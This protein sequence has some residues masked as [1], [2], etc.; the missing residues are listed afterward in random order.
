MR[1]I[2]FFTFGLSLK[3]WAEGGMLY[4]EVAFYNELTKKGIDIVFLTYGDDT[5]FGFTEIIKG[6][7]VIPVYSITKKP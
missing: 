4:R 1:L 2:L 7:K 5:D 6:I 3:K